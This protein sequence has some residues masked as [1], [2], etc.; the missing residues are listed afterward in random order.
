MRIRIAGAQLAVTTDVASNVASLVRA[1]DWASSQGADMLLTPEGSLSGYTHDLNVG[2]V[3]EG[4]GSVT[5]RARDAHLGLALGTCLIEAEDGQ[6]YNQL[7]FYAPDGTYLGFH[8]K[9]LT[10]GSLDDPPRGEIEHY[11]VRALRAFS[12]N[13]VKIGGLICN[14]LWANPG[15]TPVPDPHLCQQL[16]RMG[17]RIV[18]HAV[19]GGRD[20]SEWADVA[21]RYH[22]AN[23]RMRARAGNVW[24]VTVDNCFPLDLRCSAPSGVVDPHGEWVCR[25]APQGEQFFV[26][27]IDIDG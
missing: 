1:V 8:S 24:V 7:R 3:E 9:T 13:G 6:C 26:Q 20:G 14:D 21:W 23:L 4:L 18:F 12:L 19:N 11:A 2:L 22:E 5:A 25:A 17:A 15:C 10:C 27:S 16:S